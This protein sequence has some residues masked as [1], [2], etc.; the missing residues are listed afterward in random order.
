MKTLIALSVILALV[1][2]TAVAA[3]KQDDNRKAPPVLAE[4]NRIVAG[5]RLVQANLHQREIATSTFVDPIATYYGGYT[6][7]G[8]PYYGGGWMFSSWMRDIDQE[9]IDVTAGRLK[10]KTEAAA[11]PVRKA[12]SDFDT[13]ALMLATT[14][15]A[16]AKVD[17]FQAR[18][19]TVTT[20]PFGRSR[21][22]FLAQNSAPQIA[23]VKYLYDLSPDFTQI[24]VLV[25][26]TIERKPTGRV[27]PKAL[28]D[29]IYHQHI[30]SIVQLR[31]PS[32]ELRDNAKKWSA[33]GGKLAKSA[34]TS[35]FGQF[36]TLIP[37][38]LN[39]NQAQVTVFADK[40]SPKAYGGGF[41]GTLI[42]RDAT[43]PSDVL[44][45]YNGLIHFQTVD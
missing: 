2:N 20:D 6:I 21:I 36:Q 11:A 29:I 1:A 25:D 43:D 23:F 12:L 8:Y 41:Y 22:D 35:A 39:L 13:T 7:D 33:D 44:I 4:S 40:K 18:D 9:R 14:K 34:L 5:G 30:L 24:R 28:T 38:V 16:L 42:S 32:Y 27:S 15:A 10:T 45:W 37:Y 31:A 19:Y 3:P 26:I 17:W